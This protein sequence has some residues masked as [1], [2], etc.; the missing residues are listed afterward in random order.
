MVRGG[1]LELDAEEVERLI[2]VRMTRQ[3]LLSRAGR[4]QLWA[5]LDEAAIR[6]LIGGPDVMRA[7][8]RHLVEVSR[9]GKT[10]VQ[11]VP[12]QVGAHP[13]TTGPFII[14]GFAE[15][16]EPDVVYME[17]IGGNLSV[18]KPEDVQHYATA[19]DHLRAVALSPADTRTMLLAAAEAPG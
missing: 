6:R 12:Y 14:L 10:T 9:Q 5:I 8:L 7:Q 13:G 2:E 16:G 17:T 19:F 11:V 1:P 4:P 3:Q 18:D 15:P